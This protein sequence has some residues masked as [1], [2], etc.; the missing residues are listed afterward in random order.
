MLLRFVISSLLGSWI[1]HSTAR[2]FSKNAFPHFWILFSL[3]SYCLCKTPESSFNP[4]QVVLLNQVTTKFADG[5]FQLTLALGILLFSPSHI[6]QL[7]ADFVFVISWKKYYIVHQCFFFLILYV[8]MEQ[9]IVGLMHAPIASFYTGMVM[10]DTHISISLHLFDQPPHPSRL[11][12]KVFEMSLQIASVSGWCRDRYDA[13]RRWTTWVVSFSF[14]FYKLDFNWCQKQDNS[15]SFFQIPVMLPQ[16]GTCN[17]L[18]TYFEKHVSIQLLS[19]VTFELFPTIC[20]Y[21][22]LTGVL[23]TLSFHKHKF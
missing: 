17:A 21:F 18:R 3:F 20:S 10:N 22:G 14:I 15:R 12:V 19:F 8:F 7:N 16:C 13:K 2:I 4:K 11:Q 1:K 5:S 9:V 23:P 6:N